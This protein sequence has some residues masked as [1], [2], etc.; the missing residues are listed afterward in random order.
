MFL[1][2]LAFAVFVAAML[3]AIFVAGFR[4]AGPWMSGLWFFL[5]VLLAAW[6]GGV[7]ARPVGPAVWGVYWVPFLWIGL[8]VALLLA[9]A[10]P[11]RRPRSRREPAERAERRESAATAGDTVLSWFFWGLLVGLILALVLYYVPLAR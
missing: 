2:E 3:T 6:V 8:L 5:I 11:G 7:W 4:R 1:A 10:T 9:A